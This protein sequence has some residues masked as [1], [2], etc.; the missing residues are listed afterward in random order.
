MGIFLYLKFL[1]KFLDIVSITSMRACSFLFPNERKM[2]DIS[3]INTQNTII[4]PQKAVAANTVLPVE[5]KQKEGS[6]VY[7]SAELLR[8]MNGIQTVSHQ[9]SNPVKTAEAQQREEINNYLHSLPITGQVIKAFEQDE[10]GQKV[11][12]G[13][14]NTMSKNNVE[15]SNVEMLLNLVENKKVHYSAL[16]YF[17]NQG[18]MSDDYEK[19]LELLYDS[20]IEKK[21]EKEAFVP[22]LKTPEE[23]L[24]SREIGD[25]FQVDGEENIYIRTSENE[26]KQL[27]MSRNTYL[28]L[29]PPLERYALYQGDAGNCYM[30]SCLDS[31]NSNPRTREKL[32]GCFEENGDKLNV[33]L[34]NS[35]YTFTMDKKKMPAEIKNFKEQYSMGSAGFKILEHV[36][37]KDVQEK[38]TQEAHEILKDQSQNAKGF[39]TKR[40]FKKQLAEFEKELAK[41]PDNII[42]DRNISDQSVSWNDSIGVDW[43][44]L[45][46]SSYNKQFTRASDYYRGR[47]G[48]EE[49]VLQ[50][51]GFENPEKIFD[52]TSENEEKAKDLLFNPNNKDKYVFTAFSSGN[53]QDLGVEGLLDEDYGVYTRHSFSVK[54][55]I[56][57]NGNKLL[58]VS[59]PWN[60]T[61]SSVMTYE[62]FSE[63]FT[64]LIFAKAD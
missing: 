4:K 32:L 48:H 62:K 25:V 60:S 6:G 26:T 5:V 2:V 53:G 37:G 50:R 58:H 34:P 27:K 41:N 10:E 31:I 47:G 1:L 30:L 23:A 21:D 29:F 12:N 36:Y 52:L 54:P 42:I 24:S 38:L 33:S 56:D 40:M 13:L 11:I 15:T 43:Q 16:L 8:S 63:F 59:N 64:G 28:K 61:Q 39:F 19:D 35:D 57:K 22:T 7:P 14:I 18:I 55:K 9:K 46:E 44:K 49:W 45:D 17:C 51:F 20:Y 3:R